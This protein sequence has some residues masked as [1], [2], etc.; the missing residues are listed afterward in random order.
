[1]RIA[2]AI[3]LDEAQRVQLTVYARGRKVPLRLS[4]RAKIVLL[5]ADGKQNKEIAQ[6]L[7]TTPA[8]AAR[9]R[10]RFLQ[11]GVVGI[12]TDAPRPGRNPSVS[13]EQVQEIV[14]KTTQEKPPQVTQWSTR[15]MARASGVSARRS[16]ALLWVS[17]RRRLQRR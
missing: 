2:P 8:A 14:R 17:E 4:Q 7:A 13:S 6:L 5:A 10:A 15:S 11:Q 12:E 3:A 9:W 16:M 1:M